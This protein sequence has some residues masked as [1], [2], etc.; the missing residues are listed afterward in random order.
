MT[1]RPAVDALLFDIGGVVIDIDFNRVFAHWS[2]CA[3]CDQALLASR[4][5][6]DE[7]YRRHEVGAIGVEEYF[8]SLR[9]SLGIDLS[10]DDMLAGWN[11][12][13][14]DQVPGI[15]DLLARAGAHM[16]LYAFS[17]TN[18]SHEASWWPRYASVLGHFKTVFTSPNIGLRKPEAQA[19]EF[20]A[21][22][23]GA[24]A[25]RI[26]FFDDSQANI[27]GARAYGMQTVLVTSI[28]DVTR[29]LEALQL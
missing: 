1:S 19:F 17:N 7:P 20:V 26:L 15:A 14:I 2:A 6:M 21:R 28:A 3:G 24:P 27:D 10:H 23:I 25:D 8:A 5:S 9:Q 16:P 13:F 11:A 29:T 18:P 22:E 12:V 4:F